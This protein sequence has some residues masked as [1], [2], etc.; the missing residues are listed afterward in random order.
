[1][2]KQQKQAM[3]FVIRSNLEDLGGDLTAAAADTDPQEP[4]KVTAVQADSTP[5]VN[6]LDSAENEKKRK[7][8]ERDS[9]PMATKKIHTHMK[10]WNQK[11]AEL[12]SPAEKDMD[13]ADLSRMACLLC[14]RKFKSLKELRRH[15]D[16]SELH[17]LYV[18]NDTDQVKPNGYQTN[19]GNEDVIEKARKKI[20]AIVDRLTREED[21]AANE[22]N[23]I[24]YRNRAAER[25]MAFGQPDRPMPLDDDA[26][27]NRPPRP[28]KTVPA[29]RPVEAASV[30]NPMSESNVGARM[31]KNMGWR[32]GEGL[33]KEGTGIIAPVTAESY[34]KGA[35][36][37]TSGGRQDM[38]ELGANNSY[39]DRAKFIARKRY[40]SS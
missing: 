3:K 7:R 26:Y 17:K 24:S 12:A 37:G 14:Q 30:S 1:M 38:E 34:V 25:R 22:D 16:L 35:G 31:L 15:E 23:Q 33:G 36:L 5:T 11:Q 32:S 6:T 27:N 28:S 39:K 21:S 20:A 9:V 10:V 18:R 8:A 19:L 40:E 29:S 2:Q 13:F 4:T